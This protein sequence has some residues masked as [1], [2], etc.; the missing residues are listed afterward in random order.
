GCGTVHVRP[1]L[2]RGWKIATHDGGGK[3]PRNDKG[4]RRRGKRRRP[5]G[6]AEERAGTGCRAARS[7]SALGRG[8]VGRGGLGRGAVGRGGLLGGAGPLHRAGVVEQRLEPGVVVL[9]ARL[10]GVDLTNRAVPGEL[11]ALGG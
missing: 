8:A 11:D 10:A 6:T 9:L 5:P 3:S 7:G 2:L 4:G 1:A